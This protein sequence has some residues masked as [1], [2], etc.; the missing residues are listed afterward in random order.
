[1][2]IPD[3]V[4]TACHAPLHSSAEAPDYISRTAAIREFCER[5]NIKAFAVDGPIGIVPASAICLR[6]LLIDDLYPMHRN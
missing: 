4:R 1:V 3:L 5:R 6:V 2:V